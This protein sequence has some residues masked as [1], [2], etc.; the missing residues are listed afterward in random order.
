M[1]RPEAESSQSSSQELPG[2]E[3]LGVTGVV[4]LCF[5]GPWQVVTCDIDSS[6]NSPDSPTQTFPLFPAV[7]VLCGAA[8]CI[9]GG[10]E[11]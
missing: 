4:A 7:G 6:S 11:Q 3:L 9:L 8:T 10:M 1:G 2:K 5:A